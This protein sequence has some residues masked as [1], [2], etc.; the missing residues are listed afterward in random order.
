MSKKGGGFDLFGGLFDFNGDGK[1]DLGEEW[2]AFKIF[3]ECTKEEEPSH[4]F[5]DYSSYSSS[6][7]EID[8]IWREYCE[9]GSEYGID[10]EDYETEEEYNEALAAA[11]VAWRDTC[12]DGSAFGVD[13]EDY[14]TEEEYNEAISKSVS[15]SDYPNRR[16]YN[17]A[18]ELA[19]INAGFNFFA[20]EEE[21]N[22]TV[23]MCE[24][25]LNNPDIIAAQ[26]LTHEN[27]FLYAQAVKENFELPDGVEI[28][29]EDESAKNYIDEVIQRVAR[30][31]ARLALDIWIWCIDQFYPYR[32]YESDETYIVNCLLYDLDVMP[33]EFIDALLER[34]SERDNLMKIILQDCEESN[35]AMQYLGYEMLRKG[36]IASAI[37]A[38]RCF[39]SGKYAGTDKIC[40]VI[41]G[42]ASYA[43]NYDEL[44][45]AERLKLNLF[46]IFMENLQPKV[47]KTMKKWMTAIDSYIGEMERTDEQYAYSRRYAWRA[48]CQDGSEW[49]VDP[50]DFETEE[51]YYKALLEAKY[52]WRHWHVSEAKEYGLNLNDFEREEDFSAALEIKEAE[53]DEAEEK[54][55]QEQWEAER[56]KREEA[57]QQRAEEQ[58]RHDEEMRRKWAEEKRQRLEA[59]KA[60]DP[61]MDTDQTVYT[62]C[63]VTFP[64]TST[65]YYYRTDDDTLAVGDSVVVPVGNDG[66]DVIVEIETVEKHRRKTAPYPVDKAKFIKYRYEDDDTAKIIDSDHIFCPVAGR[67]ITGTECQEIVDVSEDEINE[68]ILM[69]FD[70]PLPFDEG[71]KTR[72]KRCKYHMQ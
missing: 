54:R 49:D 72:C 28:E 34:L 66:K 67:V 40:S 61:L 52:E 36:D 43:M 13:P 3:E 56:R 8:H 41:E 44:E 62:F 69:D 25:I 31:D 64:H 10:P 45:T 53:A 11:K 26:Y 59:E 42:L 33:D 24:F 4:D 15:P 51:E 2:L 18:N 57:F 17:A 1:T 12:E 38:L 14:E 23:E 46:P 65:V 47:Q 32:K 16:K 50:I 5:S 71:K 6:L 20:S 9:D 29:D 58:R 70:P 60:A 7:D 27:E 48:S 68:R 35:Q 55:R 21:K 19:C 63:G 37:K 39:L 22:K 30:E